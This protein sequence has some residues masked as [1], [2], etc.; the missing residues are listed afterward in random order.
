MRIALGVEYNGSRYSGWQVQRHAPSVQAAL[1][2][3]LGKVAD[4]PVQV[5]CA[6][7]TDAGVH[8]L[9]QVVHFDTDARRRM[10]GWRLGATS[11]LPDDIAVV[12][13]REVPESFSARFSATARRYRYVLLNRAVRPGLLQGRVGWTW[14][15]LDAAAMEAA[16]R[17]LLGEHDFSS[18]RAVDCQSRHPRRC[19][20]RLSVRRDGEFVYVDIEANAFLHHMVRNIVGTLMVVGRGERD[21]AWVEQVL[22]ARDRTRAGP[23]APASGL[24]FVAVDY[25]PRFALP[26]PPGP[27]VFP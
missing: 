5:T 8:A 23:T 4:A 10:H 21:P 16:G 15:P 20:A 12:W 6:G 13:A 14:A 9:G 24:Y 19:I 3:A 25:P 1:E 18:F 11:A 17:R 27:P 22:A 7:R 2:R 26:P